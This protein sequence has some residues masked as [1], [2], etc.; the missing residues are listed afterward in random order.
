MSAGAPHR[1][2]LDEGKIRLALGDVET[3]GLVLFT[4]ALYVF[5]DA[6]MGDPDEGIDQMDPTEMWAGF[7]ARYGTW[8]T[9]EG[10][11][12]LNA[13]ITGLQDGRFWRDLDTFMAVSTALFDG[14][15][16]DIITVGFEELS[17]VE[18]MWAVLE[19]QLALDSD[20]TPEY[21]LAVQEY[22]D[23]ILF[24]EQEDQG[25]NAKEVENAYLAM[26]DQLVELGVPTSMI[27]AMDEEYSEVMD[28]LADGQLG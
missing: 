22:V 9:E 26:L 18:L 3:P 28:N 4:I 12:K 14:D 5:G 25:E 11:N 17:A 24:R 15:M 1:A 10:E 7:N 8:V 6:V 20:E 21:S 16:G 27:R 13:I 2:E 23:G 19:M